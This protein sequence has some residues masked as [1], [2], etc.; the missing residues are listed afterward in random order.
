MNIKFY[1]FTIITC[2]FF[3]CKNTNQNIANDSTKEPFNLINIVKSDYGLIFTDIQ[4]NGKKIKA[5]I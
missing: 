2:L 3:S 4:V 5:M 1:I